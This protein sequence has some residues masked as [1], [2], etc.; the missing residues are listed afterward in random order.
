MGLSLGLLG[1]GGSI[2]TVPI[3][4]YVLGFPAKESIAMGLAVVGTT[5]LVGAAL[6]GRAGNVHLRAA[7]A[8]GGLAMAGT[9]LG[10]RLSAHVPGTLQLVA[11][12]AVMLVAALLMLR[13]AGPKPTAEAERAP[14]RRSL[15]LTAA[16]SLAVGLLTGLV[17]VGGGFLIVP[18]LVLFAGLPMKQAVGSSLLVIA[19]NAFVG[20]A[21]YLGQVQVPW[22]LLGGFT[23]LAAVGIGVG[24]ALV[25]FV[26][27]AALKRAFSLFLVLMGAFILFKN[28]AV[29]T[30]SGA[31]PVTAAAA[32]ARR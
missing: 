5:S 8:F 31:P 1:G 28:R 19:L 18:A 32:A 20:F 21:G 29:L 10:A 17:G 30:G 2:L 3:F 6:H 4:V 9:W 23:L 15:P 11:F 27:Q 22:A 7:L 26:S 12:A 14:A 25:R 24:T 13:S 16:V